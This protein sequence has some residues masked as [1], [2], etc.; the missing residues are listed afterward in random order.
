MCLNL[1]VYGGD[2]RQSP[3]C[4]QLTACV[5]TGGGWGDAGG[6]QWTD[7]QGVRG[8]MVGLQ[9][10]PSAMMFNEYTSGGTAKNEVYWLKMS[11]LKVFNYYIAE[12][13]LSDRHAMKCNF[14]ACEGVVTL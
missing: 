10:Q 14:C 9:L 6:E 2:E 12:M 8:A 5:R 7:R 4:R 3:L 11:S 1:I 13:L